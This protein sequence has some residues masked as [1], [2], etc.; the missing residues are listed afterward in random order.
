MVAKS[1]HRVPGF[2]DGRA[3]KHRVTGVHGTS[4]TI[5]P[6][7]RV[8]WPVHGRADLVGPLTTAA[9]VAAFVW[10]GWQRRWISDDGLIV[11]RT[12]RQVLAGNGPVFNAA[13]RA[14]ANTST[15]WT[16]LLVVVGFLTGSRLEWVSLALGLLL[17]AVGVA[18]AAWGTRRLLGL[19]GLW[20][21]A[22]LAVFVAIPPARD[23]VTSGLETGLILAYLGVAW[24]LAVTA[25][26][27][28]QWN[29]TTMVVLGLAPLVRPE[30]AVFGAV[31]FVSLV[32]VL[33][34][35]PRRAVAWVVVA[36]AVPAVYQVFRMGYYGMVV[37]ATALAKEASVARWAQGLRYVEDLVTPY[38]LVVPVVLL[39][40]ATVLL[41]RRHSTRPQVVLSGAAGLSGLLLVGYV[42]RVGGDFMHGRMLLPA[43]FVLLLPT[44]VVPLTRGIAPLALACAVWAAVVGSIV[45][46]PYAGRISPLGISDERGWWA[47]TLGVGHPVRAEDYTDNF[48]VAPDGA[49][50]VLETPGR[51]FAVFDPAVDRWLAFPLEEGMGSDA[52]LWSNI[53]TVGYLVPLDATVVDPIGLANP[54]AGHTSRLEGRRPGHDKEL[55]ADYAVADLV[56]AQH[57]PGTVE[58]AQA[59]AVLDCPKVR[60]LLAAIREPMTLQ[61]FVGNFAG[62][63]E[64]TRWRIDSDPAAAAHRGCP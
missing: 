21:P 47:A 5:A 32:L 23:F 49:R 30:L 6:P 14:E 15:V 44:A 63:W 10:S 48:T 11:L 19:S 42:V 20:F 62:A 4:T 59:S 27:K 36:G 56:P 28:A 2:T 64:R 13:E 16:Y 25:A 24:S 60:E 46:V 53:G 58:V 9:V 1:R 31:V 17:S 39:A 7:A 37:P 12:V 43:L 55:D 33:R 57:R 35:R 40:T 26:V 61:R 38:A 34:P 51:Q 3:P 52:V 8:P 18:A 41:L 45:D 54:F 22:G 50:A 29:L